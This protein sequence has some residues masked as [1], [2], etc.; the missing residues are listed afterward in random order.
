MDSIEAAPLS[1][2]DRAL[3]AIFPVVPAQIDQT[4]PDLAP[5]RQ[6]LVIAN[7]GAYAECASRFLA[8]R[9]RIAAF[10]TPFG[11]SSQ[12]LQLRNGPIPLSLLLE[13]EQIARD[14]GTQETAALVLASESGTGYE[15]VR[16]DILQA[17]G[18]H[19]RYD[20]S[21]I[22]LSR[23]VVDCHSHGRHASFFSATDDISDATRVGPV[24]SMVFG[25][26][27]TRELDIACRVVMGIYRIEIGA[28]E[29]FG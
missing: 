12:T 11:I 19:V 28:E 13:L 26:C 1:P 27:H 18:G 2:T 10:E 23:L 5:G 15:I 17:S 24:I 4:L 8:V 6:R 7:D 22:D 20:E 9:R 21:R 14:A 25:R 29:I 16:P 3:Q